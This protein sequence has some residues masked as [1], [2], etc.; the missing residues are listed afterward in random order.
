MVIAGVGALKGRLH[1]VVVTGHI[2]ARV[3]AITSRAK[4]VGSIGMRV[5]IC[6]SIGVR[7]IGSSAGGGAV[8]SEIARRVGLGVAAIAALIILGQV[9]AATVFQL[10]LFI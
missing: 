8:M 3:V 6:C 2:G 1:A 10:T 5:I 4:L 7:E 9:L